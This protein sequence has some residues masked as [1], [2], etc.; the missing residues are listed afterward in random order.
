MA[1]EFEELQETKAIVKSG[2][3]AIH[4]CGDDY[5]RIDDF[6]ERLALELRFFTKEQAQVFGAVE[7]QYVE[8]VRVVEW[9]YGYGQ[10]DFKTKSKIGSLAGKEE[11]DISQFLETYKDREYADKTIILIRNARQ[12]MEGEM[13]RKNLAQLQQTIVHL[14]KF[15]PG[16]A[17]LIYCDE[18]R[19]IPDET[20]QKL[21]LHPILLRQTVLFSTVFNNFPAFFL[22]IN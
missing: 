7:P 15:S 22:K 5:G 9:N 20:A 4:I 8:K 3:T 12:V 10:V 21:F 1:K 13:N 17:V 14:K 19:F 18:R 2:T 11:M 16:R 6:V